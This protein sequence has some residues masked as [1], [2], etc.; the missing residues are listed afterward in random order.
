[1]VGL[2]NSLKF[3]AEQP[4]AARH[5]TCIDTGSAQFACVSGIERHSEGV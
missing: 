4:D 3:R 1:M 5:T 2:D